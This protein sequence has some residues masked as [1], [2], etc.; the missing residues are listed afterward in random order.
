LRPIFALLAFAVGVVLAFIPG[1]AV[2]FFGIAAA[3]LASE[4][5]TVARA[6]DRV[7]VWLRGAWRRLRGPRRRRQRTA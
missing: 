5:M 7:E 6:L 1:P 2:V 4:S 3:L